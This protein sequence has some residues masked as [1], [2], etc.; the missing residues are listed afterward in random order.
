MRY[1]IAYVS[2][3][4]PFGNRSKLKVCREEYETDIK[5]YDLASKRKWYTSTYNTEDENISQ[6]KEAIDYCMELCETHN[7][8]YEKCDFIE[9]Y[10]DT[11]DYLD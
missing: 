3:G 5:K 4:Y 6:I 8:K 9:D 10:E 7:K 11:N 1:F 2:E